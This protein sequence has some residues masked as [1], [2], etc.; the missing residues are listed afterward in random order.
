MK[1]TFKDSQN[2]AR[3]HEYFRKYPEGCWEA[4]TDDGQFSTVG[5]DALTAAT[6]LVDDLVEELRFQRLQ[7]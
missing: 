6:K 1:L 4:A 2:F 3:G 5:A 7:G